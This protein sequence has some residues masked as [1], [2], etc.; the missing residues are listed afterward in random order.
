MAVINFGEFQRILDAVYAR[1]PLQK[2]R[3]DKFIIN[4]SEKFSLEAEHFAKRYM[5]YIESQGLTL[6]F[7]ADSYV[8]MCKC[9][10][11]L[12]IDFK[13]TGKYPIESA[14]KAFDEVYSDAARMKGYM[15]A[16]AVSQFLWDSHY[17]IF[18]CFAEAIERK[19]PS[20]KA[21]L[22]IGP[23]HGLFLDKALK[24]VP[25]TA[26]IKAVD[27]SPTSI[28]ISRS[29]IEHF[30][31]HAKHIN[32]ITCDM[33]KLDINEKY[34]FIALGEVIEH[35]NDPKKLLEKLRVLLTPDGEGFIS[36][37]ANCP[38]VDHVYHFHTV[39]EIRDLLSSA[40]LKIV[41]ELV[42]PVED[43][44]MLKIVEQK[45]TINYCAIVTRATA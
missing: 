23:G 22:E 38:A 39:Q 40:G 42:L 10:L 32:F 3:I 43:L 26:A 35:V 24:C 31:P 4:A 15:V 16:L 37:C 20:V 11:K 27:I 36:T 13:K 28:E 7:V 19:G 33:L 25:A 29:I 6:D 18:N 2:K 1:S 5:A 8:T 34:D 17:K 44:P 41:T 30:H 14:D 9:M 45:I 12:Q 21:Y